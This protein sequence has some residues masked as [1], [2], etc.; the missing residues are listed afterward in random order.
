MEPPIDTRLRDENA[1]DPAASRR[2][3]R[4]Q[5]IIV[6]A[7]IVGYALLSHYSNSNPDATRLG[8]G[9]SLG[10]IL[11]IGSL[12]L[13]R[14]AHPLVAASV[15]AVASVLLYQFWPFSVKNYHWADLAQQC[16]AYALVAVSFARS[17]FAGRQP[18]CTQL[19][20]RL[21]G[22]LTP[23]EVAY[24]RRATIVWT[25]FYGLL[26][27]VIL[28]LYVLAPLRI[29]SL[30]VNFGTFALIGLVFAADH[31]LRRRLL[32]RRPGSGLLAAL[33]QSLTG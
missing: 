16:G 29:W 18:M 30:F 6:A 7:V 32:P 15:I 33:R 23:V 8:A 11:L 28:A 12:L 24:T 31:A 19:A 10:P 25:V 17:L 1:I 13:W 14:W 20:D 9:L 3:T 5:L 22:P 4:F 2:A 27:A 26:A 21:H